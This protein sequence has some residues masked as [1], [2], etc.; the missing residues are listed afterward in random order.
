MK[1]SAR[2]LAPS[3]ALRSAALTGALA[4]AATLSGCGMGSSPVHDTVQGAALNGMVHGGQ[5]PITGATIQLYQVGTT[6][7][8]TG[9]AALL[10][11]AV[12][13]DASGSFSITGKYTC[14]STSTL[15]YITATGGNPGGGTN[16]NSK[17]MAALGACGNL[18]SSTYIF[19]DEV[20]TAAAAFALTPYFSNAISATSTDGFGSPNTTQALA[21]ITNAFATAATLANTTTGNANTAFTTNGAG[22]ALT[23]TPESA[24]LYTIADVLA[25]CVNSTGGTSGDGT[26]CGTLF[27]DSGPTGVTPVNTLQA[28]V[29]LNRNPT[30]SN[31]N[32][33]TNNLTALFGLVSATSPYTAQTTQ[34]TDWT[35]GVTYTG[36]TATMYEPQNVAIDSTGNVWVINNG[37]SQGGS[38]NEITPAGSMAVFNSLTS[39]AI[40]GNTLNPRNL[41]IDVN[42]N[43]WIP[44]S[45]S[46]GN[47]F[48]YTPSGTL[49]TLAI[50]KSPYGVAIDANNNVWFGHQSTSNTVG[51]DEFLGANLA[52]TSQVSY[53]VIGSTTN[54]SQYLAFD[55]NGNLWA[56]NGTSNPANTNVTEATGLSTAS[57]TA[58]PCT[59]G[60]AT[61]VNVTGLGANPFS[62]S[63]SAT[64]MWVAES[65]GPNVSSITLTN[66]TATNYGSSA[67]L[68]TPR[69]TAVDGAGNIWVT[70]RGTNGITEFSSNGTILSPA[71]V[72]P[73]T[74]PIGFVHS[75]L[76]AGNQLAIDP[77]G[78]IWVADNTITA[79]ANVN[80]IFELVGAAAPTVTPTALALKNN[81]IGV[82]P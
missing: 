43:I 3:L 13:T 53:P 66:P 79:G 42:N 21:G 39:G 28:A 4:L 56:A 55:V 20:T 44:T 73:A 48:E 12:T 78:N 75:G 9:A 63:A 69:F 17:L 61:Y 40:T 11:S 60:A 47:V 72:A 24:K 2:C 51:F 26:S 64:S 82:K 77:S 8:G 54:L 70:N 19:M 59:T 34:P 52:T 29:L 22:G 49:L 10:T 41:A 6:G 31:S 30:S 62:L 27:A 32:G 71:A 14:P 23:V 38:L 46:A 81:T 35:L 5:Q 76:S 37:S 16:A 74:T 80:T 58:F 36:T 1:S 15:V 68:T 65:G 45:S 57:C 18:S 25:A 7:Y 67:S 33:S 50:G